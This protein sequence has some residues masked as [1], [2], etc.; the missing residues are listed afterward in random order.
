MSNGKDEATVAPEVRDF[1]N[2]VAD[3]LLD[4]FADIEESLG[5]DG[6]S[7]REVL[8]RVLSD[9]KAQRVQIEAIL[10]G[11]LGQSY[12]EITVLERVLC[13]VPHG[14]GV[15][16][17]TLDDIRAG[18]E[19]NRKEVARNQMGI[20]ALS[21]DIQHRLERKEDRVTTLEDRVDNIVKRSKLENATIESLAARLGEAARAL[22]SPADNLIDRARR[23]S[24]ALN[25]IRSDLLAEL[26]R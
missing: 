12:N 1:E 13:L 16:S 20:D 18:I 6:R 25:L 10:N 11:L 2:R 9:E 4:V 8:A 3:G 17:Q 5:L 26:S 23:V 24:A 19:K 21:L 7:E 22:L 14:D 15:T